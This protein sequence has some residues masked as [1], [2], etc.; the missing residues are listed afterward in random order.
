MRLRSETIN[1]AW[2]C[3]AELYINLCYLIKEWFFLY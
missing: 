2:A 1:K 3:E